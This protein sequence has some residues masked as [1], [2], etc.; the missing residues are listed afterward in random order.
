M[1][2]FMYVNDFGGYLPERFRDYLSGTGGEINSDAYGR[3]DYF[4]YSSLDK[5]G[6]L[7]NDTGANIGQLMANRY[8]GGNAFNWNSYINPAATNYAQLNPLLESLS[9][10]PIRWDPGQRPSNLALTDYYT[11]YT[12]N[13]HW[14]NS[15]VTAG[16]YVTWYKKLHDLSPNKALATDQLYDIGDCAHVRGNSMAVNI[17][18]KDGHVGT[19]TDT[20]VL[21]WLKVSAVG[22]CAYSAPFSATSPP[23]LDDVNDVLEC[24]ALGKNPNTTIADPTGMVGSVTLNPASPL[25]NR[26]PIAKHPTVPW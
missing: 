19:A 15:G 22:N 4:K 1:A 17:L 25:Q 20:I 9:W 8:L 7:T 14:A 11:A 12:F 26:L 6:A 2:T 3:I 24:E 18:F 13:P 10:Y 21:K 16:A 5:G 23:D